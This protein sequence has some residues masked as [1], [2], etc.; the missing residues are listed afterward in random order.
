MH[1]NIC[2]YHPSLQ[3]FT[4]SACTTHVHL[5]AD[6]DELTTR[7]IVPIVMDYKCNIIT[8]NNNYRQHHHHQHND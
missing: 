8:T 5:A 2:S 1:P 4:T 6:A 7:N 3:R